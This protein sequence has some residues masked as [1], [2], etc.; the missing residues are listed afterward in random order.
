[1]TVDGTDPNDPRAPRPSLAVLAD[2]RT[3]LA[4]NRSGLAL[5]ACG[6]VIMRGLTLQHFART[7]VAVGAVILGLGMLSY[8]VAGWQ[9]RRRL[10][11]GRATQPATASDLVPVA[12]SVTAIGVAAFVL[13]L[14]FPA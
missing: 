12:L 9:A 7:D 1:M 14:L 3:D 10:A 6:L 13:G 11:P 5:I 4:W 2:E 8:L